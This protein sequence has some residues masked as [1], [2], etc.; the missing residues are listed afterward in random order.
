MIHRNTARVAGLFLMPLIWCGPASGQINT[1]VAL[2]PYV[3][4]NIFRL[5]YRYTERS[6]RGSVTHVNASTVRGTYVHGY[7]DGLAFFLSMPY[8]NRQVDINAADGSRFEDAHDGLGDITFLAKYRFW[9][10]DSAPGKTMRWAVLGGLNVRSG[11]SDF[12]SDSYDPIAGTVFSLRS[13]RSKF[14]AD[15]VYQ[16]N[17]G[18]GDFGHDA[19]RYDLSYG[20]RFLPAQFDSKR[21]WELV[22]VAE[23]NGRY[24]TDGSH[25]IFL[26]PGIQFKTELWIFETSIQL[27]VVSE[28]TGPETDY[29]LIF[30]FRFQW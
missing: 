4:G 17:T 8:A 10:D 3:G 14:D 29:T 28:V 21:P 7:R 12:S 9:R 5:Q 25:Q 2:T 15:L 6:G 11:D 30:G 23:L 19:L 20:Y 27:P 1:D 13:G 18:T 16:L 26:S 24:V 22:G